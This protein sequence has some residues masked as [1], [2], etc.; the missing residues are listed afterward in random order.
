MHSY[1]Q[2]YGN[3]IPS[4]QDNQAIVLSLVKMTFIT[5]IG[6]DKYKFRK[7]VRQKL[8]DSYG[9]AAMF[10]N[11]SYAK[12]SWILRGFLNRGLIFT[13][14]HILWKILLISFI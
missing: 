11:L 2:T 8:K 7:P 6:D 10:N 12:G 9:A 4:Y 1:R 3:S 13:E 14:K 5:G